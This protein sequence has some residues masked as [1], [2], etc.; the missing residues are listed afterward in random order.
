MKTFPEEW[1]SSVDKL[2]ILAAVRSTRSRHL[3]RQ[4][5]G[6]ADSLRQPADAEPLRL[7]NLPH[8]NDISTMLR[9]LAQMGVGHAR[10]Q[11]AGLVLMPVADNPLAPY[12]LVKTMR[13]SI[14]VLGPLVARCGEAACRCQAACAIGARRS[15]STSR[16]CRRW[17]RNHCRGRLYVHAQGKRLKGRASVPT[18]S[19]SPAPRT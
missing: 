16:A 19:P 13:A 9:L 8:L 12:D 6:A 18:W 14:L 7:D 2:I 10:R 3:R 11:S 5:P 4:E 15:T 1:G 17:G